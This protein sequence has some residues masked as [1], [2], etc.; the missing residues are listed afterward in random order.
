MKNIILIVIIGLLSAA[1]LPG[2]TILFD[3]RGTAGTGLLIGNENPAVITGGSGGEVGAGITYDN[4]SRI[5]TLNL[6]WGASNGF[7]NL[8]GSTTGGHIHGPTTS[9]G[10]AAFTQNASVL[11]SLDTLPGWN[12][13]ASAG[14][15]TNGTVTL[16]AAQETELLAGRYYVNV[17]TTTNSGG[18]IRGYLTAVPEPDRAGLIGLGIILS[19]L[20][21]KRKTPEPEK[22]GCQEA[23]TLV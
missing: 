11:F 9:G 20:R 5:L 2:A 12:S 7:T 6:G 17:H 14:G 23:H 21:R 15:L 16:T 18:E 4:V 3:L 13:S 22:K 8:T 10:T 19:A 1:K